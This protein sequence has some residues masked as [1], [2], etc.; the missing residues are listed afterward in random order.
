MDIEQANKHLMLR[1]R[2]VKLKLFVVIDLK[3]DIS[4]H[5]FEVPP[6]IPTNKIIYA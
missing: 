4:H 6:E 5:F 2:E 1:I 3:V